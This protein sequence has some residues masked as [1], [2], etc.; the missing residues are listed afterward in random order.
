[1]RLTHLTRRR[2]GFTLIELLIVIAIILILIAIA[3]PNFLEAQIRARVTKAKGEL[4]T[5]AIALTSYRLDWNIYPGRGDQNYADPSVPRRNNGLR[6]LTSPIAYV[7]SLPD[8]PFPVTYTADTLQDVP[9]PYTYP[10]SGVDWVPGQNLLHPHGGGLLRAWYIYSAGPDAPE[11]EIGNCMAFGNPI[12]S[13]AATNGTKSRGDLML[14]GGE[15][16]WMGLDITDRGCN[17]DFAQLKAGPFVGVV[18]D[19]QL[20]IRKFPGHLTIG[21]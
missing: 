11:T 19:D 16:Q 9:G 20:Y 5:V 13:Y 21:N 15:S 17:A 10:L 4:R 6:W 14:M 7:T 12:Y 18:Y 2:G 1:M 3:L 8:D